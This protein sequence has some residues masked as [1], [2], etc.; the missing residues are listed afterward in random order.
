MHLQIT[1]CMLGTALRAS[2]KPVFCPLFAIVVL[3]ATAAVYSVLAALL[4]MVGCFW[5]LAVVT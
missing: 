4:Q 5:Q 2:A 3:F 1:Y